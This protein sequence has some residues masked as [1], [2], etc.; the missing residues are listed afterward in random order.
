[1]KTTY[2]V[3]HTIF[4]AAAKAFFRYQVVGR[5]KLVLDIDGDALVPIFRRNVFQFVALVV[6]G[7]VDQHANRPQCVSD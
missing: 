2:W 3:G 4:R 6:G 7:V 5:E 1:M